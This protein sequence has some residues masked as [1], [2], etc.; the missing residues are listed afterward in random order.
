[1]KGLSKFVSIN[2]YF[3]TLASVQGPNG[4]LDQ[5]KGYWESERNQRLQKVYG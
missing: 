1:L 3:E 4:S 2:P 5:R